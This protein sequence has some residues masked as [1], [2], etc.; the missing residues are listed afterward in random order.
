MFAGKERVVYF[1]GFESSLHLLLVRGKFR[2][3]Y[4][5]NWFGVTKCKFFV[6]N[7]NLKCWVCRLAFSRLF[8]I[9][10][11]LGNV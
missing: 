4:V 5:G 1:G 10:R 8:Y 2:F 9:R 11:N 3:L 6:K 7:S